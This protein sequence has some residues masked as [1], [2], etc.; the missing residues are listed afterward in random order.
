MKPHPLLVLFCLQVFCLFS[1]AAE[2]LRVFIRSGPKSHG[3][4]A[5]DHPSF[6]RDWVPL[7]NERG[8]KAAGGDD[9]PTQAQLDQTDVLI[10]HRDGGGDFK[11]AEKPL[12]EAFTKRGGGIVVIHA[13]SVANK[14]EG[15]DYYKA[16]IGGSWRRPDT[17]WLEG[18]M[19]LYFTDRV[20]PITKD[21]SNFEMDDEMYYDMD[22][23]PEIHVLAAAYTPKPS[24]AANEK[25]AKRAAELTGGGKKVSVYD[26]QPQVWTYSKD[27]YRAFVCI[28][29]HNYSNFSRP[30]FRA[31]LLRGIAWAGKRSNVDELCKPDELGDN[32]RYVEGGPTRP[33]KAAEK[34]EIHPDFNISL[35]AS[36][37]LVN[38]AMNIDWDEKGRL[39]VCETPEYPNGRRQQ[40]TDPWKDAGSL[41]PGSFDREPQDKICWLEDTNGDG[42]MDKKHVFADKLELCTSFCFYKN[43]VIACAA[44]DIW[45]LEDTTGKGVCDK[46]TKLYTGLGTR[47]THAVINNLRW[48]LDGW[49]YATHGYSA[50]HVTSPD[51]TKD[52]GIDGSGVVRFKPDGSAFEMYA[53]KGG[54]CWGLDMTWDGQCFWTQPTSGTVFFHVVL[55]EYVLAKGKIPGTTSWKGMI[56]GQKTFPLMSWTEQAYVQIDQVGQYTAAAGCAIYEG[57][58]WPEKW[59][60]SYFVGEPTLNIVSQYFVKKDGV[61]Y[62]VEKEKG[63]EETEFIRSKDMWFRPIEERVGPDGALYI[64]DFYNQAVIHNDTR[65]PLHGP[66]NAAVRPDRDHYFSRI[67][68]VQHKQ[69]K[70]LEVPVLD[71]KSLPSLLKVIATNPSGPIKETAWNLIVQNFSTKEASEEAVKMPEPI[72][73]QFVA[74]RLRS[75]WHDDSEPLTLTAKA[76]EKLSEN[77]KRSNLEKFKRAF[78]DQGKVFKPSQL[79]ALR[80]LGQSEEVRRDYL[81]KFCETNLDNWSRSAIVAAASEYPVEY[82][83]SSLS[84]SVPTDL[85]LFVSAVTPLALATDTSTNAT[86]LLESCAT[87]PS[88]ADALKITILQGIAQQNELSLTVDSSTANALKKLLVNPGTAGATLPLVVK[89]DTRGVLADVVKAQIAGLSTMLADKA[90]PLPRRINAAKTLISIGGDAVSVGVKPLGDQASPPELQ[91]AIIEAL[92]EHGH[93]DLIV[94]SLDHLQGPLQQAAFDAVLKRPEATNTVLTLIAEGKLNPKDLGTANI[95]RLRTHPNKAVA[96]RAN[97]MMDKL[98]PGAKEK[99]ALIAKF[100]PEVEK[101]GDVAKGKMYFTSTCAICHQINGEGKLVGPPLNGMGAHG[102][103]E[104][105]VSIIDPNREVDPSFYAWNITKKNGDIFVGVIAGENTASL[106]LRNQVGE[107]EIRKDDIKIR[108]NTHRSLMPEGFEMLPPDALRDILAFI[109]GGSD[110]KFRVLDLRNAYNADSRDGIF[111]SAERKDDTVTLNKFGNVTVKGVPFF[112]MDPAKSSTGA[113]FVALKGGGKKT[114][115]ENFPERV[116]IATN[117]TAASL[118][119]LGGV[120]GW[121]WPYGGD[122]ALG[123]PAM[124]VH[125]EYADGDKESILLKNGEHFADYIQRASVPL[126]ENAGDFT[127]RGQLRYFAINLKKKAQLKKVTLETSGNIVTPC[128]VAITAGAERSADTPVRPEKRGGEAAKKNDPDADKSVR[129][130]L[131]SNPKEGGKGDGPLVAATPV[132][133]E[134]NKLK[135]LVIGGG[136]S[137]N[138]AKFFGGTDAATLSG[139]GFSVHYTEDRDQAAA[140]L[141]NA[142]VAVISVNRKFFDTPAYRKALFNRIAAGKGVIMLHPGTW[143]GYGQWPEL[144][145]QIIGG[146]AHG[147][148][149]IDTFT[150]SVLKKDHPVMAGVPATFEAVD[151][152]YHVNA[153]PGKTPEGTLPIE[154][155]A[156]TS[157]SKKYKTGHPSVWVT[158]ND[159]ARIVGIALG[160]D[161]RVHDLP[162][163]R[164]ILVNAVKWVDGK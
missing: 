96:K 32:L 73:M 36:E 65:G 124:T 26:I 25:A 141:A 91:S 83:E 86:R 71:R 95:A 11:P 70:K 75:G 105:L 5:H 7:L 120:G 98:N 43:G 24:G 39:W 102:P 89:W 81:A 113:N 85:T 146:G 90:A 151:E 111:A 129:A 103:A 31:L 56:T 138:F 52:F 76:Y 114:V 27:S 3:P 139:A 55:P 125:V 33:D 110:N 53:S 57:G 28:P 15:S 152:L 100:T 128:T 47:D 17:K 63:R 133:W 147:H 132:K 142:D 51:G 150:V 126:S 159:K 12:I 164:T 44:P 62:S 160:H 163:F 68:K 115:A 127:R 130:P 2:P 19:N 69:A 74:T 18:P 61:S 116:E 58:A 154:V 118:H 54:N 104:L 35:V 84:G 153:G 161:E 72:T 122:K 136:S 162:A 94:A 87:A 34:F 38:K 145:A 49:V 121:A 107:F 41:Y 156:E 155:L 30:N 22:L 149:A 79:F 8:A 4:G 66:A 29:G 119:F 99:N 42:V 67:W 108:E 48:G 135:V 97:A 144:N 21:C 93:A 13:G 40:N 64:V 45:Y 101:P 50:G 92:D 82:L 123:Q 117:V 112:I 106:T 60:Y 9:F 16:L 23:A 77:E 148:D 46:R 157:P 14:P 137:H 37:P 10:I 78:K 20:N 88:S 143:Y 80:I 140:E 1:P 158:K 59:N 134:P 6:L 131:E 109:C